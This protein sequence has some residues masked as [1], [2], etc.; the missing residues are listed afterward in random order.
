MSSKS[1]TDASEPGTVAVGRVLRPHGVRGEVVVE[2]TSDN[3]ERFAV[4]AELLLMAPGEVGEAAPEAARRRLTIETVRPHRGVLLVG[5]AGIGDRDEADAL[6]GE[7]AVPGSE[8]PAPPEGTWYHFQ[9]LGCRVSDRAAGELGEVV[10]LVE[11][12]G[13]LLLVVEGDGR[14]VP[15]PFVERFLVRADVEAREIEVDL[16]EG[17]I[18]ACA[19]TS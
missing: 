8:V 2:V 6:R 16:P 15:V 13:G 12:G 9:L 14:R 5:F 4:G 19:S 10:D 11:D 1:S 7:L 17:L 18:E 3:P